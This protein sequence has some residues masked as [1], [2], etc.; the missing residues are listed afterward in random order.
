M[1]CRPT[2]T[3]SREAE[4]TINKTLLFE[5]IS[6]SNDVEGKVVSQITKKSYGSFDLV[7]QDRFTV[8]YCTLMPL[9]ILPRL[10]THL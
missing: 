3:S 4:S 7:R 8:L 1:A 5:R 10:V 2:S 6:A 9:A